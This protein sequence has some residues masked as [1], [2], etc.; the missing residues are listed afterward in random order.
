MKINNNVNWLRNMAALCLMLTVFV[1]TSMVALAKPG[2][3]LAGEIIVSGHNTNGAEPLVMLN[4]ER[5]F[6]GRTFFDSGVISTSDTASA[7]VKLGKLGYLTLAPNSTMNLSFSENTISGKV[8]SGD[9]KVFNNEGV[10]V[11]VENLLP[12]QQKTDDDNDNSIL[13]PLIIFGA[14]VGTAVIFVMT[15]SGDSGSIVSPAR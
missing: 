11:N 8:I 4:G 5:A 13:V 15:N 12:R 9:V 2:S 10:N 14:A 7:T 3:S 1:S 6:S